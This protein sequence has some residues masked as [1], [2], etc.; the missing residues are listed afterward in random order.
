MRTGDRLDGKEITAHFRIMA[1]ALPPGVKA[2][3]A[4]VD[5][6]FYCWQAVEAYESRNWRFIMV[7]RKTSRLV[8]KL[9]AAEW[10]PSPHADA[11]EQCEFRYQPE[12]R[13]R[14]YRF[15][16]LRYRKRPEGK[17]AQ[18]P[19]QYQL[20]DTPVYTHRVFVTN[21]D[22]PLDALV[23]LYN[24][25]AGEENLIQEANNDAGLAAQ[26][27]TRWM[28]NANRFQIV[29]LADNLNCWLQFARR[30]P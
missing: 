23:W 15:L 22:G 2:V 11:D 25:R 19:E 9:K 30:S 3:L 18:R 20:F 7:A 26:P 13:G 28:M 29:M 6:S 10:K 16:A 21:M 24:Q 27:S 8:E 4:R 12:G 14:A 17:E 1:A 5:S